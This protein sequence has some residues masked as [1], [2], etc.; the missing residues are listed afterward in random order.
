MSRFLPSAALG[1]AALLALAGRGYAQDE[2]ANGQS[3]PGQDAPQRYEVEVILFADTGANPNEELFSVEEPAQAPAAEAPLP[4]PF[5][6]AGAELQSVPGGGTPPANAAQPL[7][8]AAGAAPATPRPGGAA[9][10]TP[11]ADALQ[12]VPVPPASGDAAGAAGGSTANAPVPAFAFRLLGPDEM[13]LNAEY[14]KIR[15]NP[16]YR[17]LG[18]AAWIQEGLPEDRARPIDLA[19][20]GIADPSGTIQLHVSRYLHVSV[21][22]IYR[23]IADGADAPAAGQT[24]PGRPAGVQSDAEAAGLG[25]V[26]VAPRYVMDQQRRVRSGELQYFDHP[27]FG[28]LLLITPAPQKPPEQPADGHEGLTPAA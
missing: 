23:R 15:R 18:H 9:P 3:A 26:E 20:L 5:G 11:S 1:L 17:P 16:A 6:T 12:A 10:R 14:A 8:D 22:L 13:K 21:N 28:L 27:M 19:D 25:T 24:A 4:V 7:N 2:T